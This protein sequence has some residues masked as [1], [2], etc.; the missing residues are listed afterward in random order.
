MTTVAEIIEEAF[1]EG[2]LTTEL[3]SP[4]PTQM[5]QALARLQSV[6]SS[7][8]GFE[9]GEPL[10]DWPLGLE[11]VNLASGIQWEREQWKYP[12]INVRLV[13]ASAEAETVYLSAQPYDGSRVALIDPSGRLAAA[14]VTVDGN[15]RT[16]EGAASQLVN[17]NGA[18][19]IWMYRADT[20][21]WTAI[22]PLTY[23]SE[24]PFPAEFDDYFIT[25]LAMRLNPRYGRSMTEESVAAHSRSLSMLRAR[26]RQSENVGVDPALLRLTEHY[27]GEGL[28]WYG[29]PTTL[30]DRGWMR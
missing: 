1:R 8:Y 22:T 11:G 30:G 25:Q 27:S 12:R 6:V 14:P 23:Q 4:T 21:N 18:Q 19:R 20:G 29:N 15:G 24:M 26:Y 5:R 13:A 7:A 3:Q 28:S 10:T 2:S 9:V 17:T 16:V